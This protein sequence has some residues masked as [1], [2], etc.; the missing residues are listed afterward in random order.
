MKTWFGKQIV[1]KIPRGEIPRQQ[2]SGKLGFEA[3][4]KACFA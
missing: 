1:T 3:D 4:A 2:L